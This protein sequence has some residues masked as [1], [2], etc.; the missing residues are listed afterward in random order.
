MKFYNFLLKCESAT[1]GQNWNVR[2]TP[3]MM[4]LVLSKLPGKAREK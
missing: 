2:D 3:E 4:C 1:L